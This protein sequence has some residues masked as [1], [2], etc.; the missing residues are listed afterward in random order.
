MA[1]T[2]EKKKQIIE[3]VK[4]IASK[5]TSLV[6]ANFHGVN[7]SDSTRMR[8][9]L[10]SKGVGY[11]VAKKTLVKKALSEA[12]FAGDIPEL[13]G[14]VALVYDRDDAGDVTLSARE[15]YAFQKEFD[16]RMSITGGVFDQRFM[17]KEEMTEI[18]MIPSLQ[19]LHAQVVNLFNSPIQGV[20]MAL[21]E[22]TKKKETIVS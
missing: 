3:K 2:K 14:E 11:Y 16:G 17:N 21:S 1:I 20:V 4:E 19:T 10:R 9:D 15:I 13:E 7:V 5:N 8:G 6:F 18:A 22:I 12:G